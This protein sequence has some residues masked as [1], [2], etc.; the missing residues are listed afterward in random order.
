MNEVTA[1]YAP[2]A[3]PVVLAIRRPGPGPYPI[4]LSLLC[5]VLWAGLTWLGFGLADHPWLS[6]LSCP[7]GAFCSLLGAYYALRA[8]RSKP[9]PAWMEAVNAVGAIFLLP[10]NVLATAFG[11]ILTQ[12]ATTGF[13]R[14]R[15]LRRLGRVLRVDRAPGMRVEANAT[16][17]S[18]P[19]GS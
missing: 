5:L 2:P 3:I 7:T 11:A 1:R 8:C 18:I 19:C 14:G 17:I 16:Q 13:Q 10:M 12:W 9:A 6:T 4:L 15:Q